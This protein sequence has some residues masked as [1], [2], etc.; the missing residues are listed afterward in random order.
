MV[1]RGQRR[2]KDETGKTYGR[3]FVSSVAFVRNGQAYFNCLC[4]CGK[5]IEVRG[6][7]LRN[8]NTKSCGCL[9]QRHPKGRMVGEIINGVIPWGKVDPDDPLGKADPSD[10]R[11]KWFVVCRWCHKFYYYREK[12]V[13]SEKGGPL[14]SCCK[15]TYTSWRKMIE[16]C[17]NKNRPQYKDYGGRGITV[18]EPWRQS[19][20][21]FLH[22]MGRRPERRTLDRR[23]NNKG[24]C[25]ENCRWATKKEQALGRRKRRAVPKRREITME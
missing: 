21:Q 24:Y 8:E 5:R 4:K 13:R 2:F 15:T 18:C 14:C 17:T 12:R 25:L 9:R 20:R 16:R 23:D 22:D 10:P 19:F 1:N 6:A 3:L 11:P 7:N